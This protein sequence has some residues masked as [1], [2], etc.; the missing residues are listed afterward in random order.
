LKCFRFTLAKIR[1]NVGRQGPNME[2]L[3]EVSSSNFQH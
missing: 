1:E 2:L 3:R